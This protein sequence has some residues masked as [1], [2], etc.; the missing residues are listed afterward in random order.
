MDSYNIESSN[1]DCLDSRPLKKPKC[2]Q[3]NDCDLSPSPRSSTSLASSCNNI[4]SSHVYDLDARPLKEVKCEQMNDVDISLSPPSATTLPSS[5]PEKDPY[6]IDSIVA[7]K[8]SCSDWIDLESDNDRRI[9]LDDEKH[10]NHHEQFKVDQTYDYLPQDYEMTDLDYCALMT[11]ESSL[12]SDI[13]VKIDDIF[14]TQS[15]LSCLLDPKKFL[16]DDVISAYI[17]CIKYQAHLESRNDVKFYF[18]NPF[19]TVILKRDGK[20]GVG[21]DGNHITKIVRNYL[22]HE[23]VLIPINIKETHWYLAIINTQKC[24]IQVLDSLCWDSNRVDLADTLQGLQFHLDIIGRQQNLISHNWKDLQIISWT[25]TE[26]VQEPMQKDGY[27]LAGILLCWKT[28]TAQTTHQN[29]SLLGS[30]NDQ[31]ETKATDSLLEETKYQSLMSILSKINENELVGGLCDYI[32]SINC[33]ETLEKV[34]VRNSKP[35]SISLTV[36]KLQEILKE[37]LPMDRDCLNLVIRKFMFDEIQMMKKTKGTISK[38]Y[39]DTRFWM[40][41]DFGR[42]P[43]FRKKLDVE[44]LAETILIP[45]VQ[46]NK[47]YILF[48]LNQDTRTVYILDPTPLDPVYKYNPNAR[49]VKKLLCIAEFLP[50]AM[51]KVCPGSRWSEDVFLW[52]QIILSD[53]PIENRELSGYFVSLFMCIW[54]DEELRLPILKDGYELRKQFMA[55]LLT[56]KENECEDNM[57]AGVRDFL[58]CINATKS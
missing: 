30:S 37:D 43:N 13:L 10:Q 51:S 3:L 20:L 33:P 57:P 36:R 40:I 9:L 2:E 8:V 4:E 16:N 45:I 18:E 22:K 1:A 23:M 6:I 31:K 28:N 17:C 35:Y 41:T 52:R 46:F 47:T 14:V 38:H 48:I 12:E 7:E 55:Q 5:S 56:Y 49:Y 19:I 11:I 44:Q 53:V 24:E 39:L 42:H 50:K 21:Q 26:Q 54:K 32:K 34:W 29:M 27:K 58:S 15:Q 25:I